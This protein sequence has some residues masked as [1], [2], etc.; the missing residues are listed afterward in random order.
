[1]S[2]I[3]HD[4]DTLPV[5]ALLEAYPFMDSYF[6]SAGLELSP[7]EPLPLKEYLHAL[8]EEIK[9]DKAINVDETVSGARSYMQ[10]MLEFLGLNS[11]TKVESVCILPGSTKSGEPEGFDRLEIRPRRDYLHCGPHRFRKKPA[12]GRHRV[13]GPAGHPHRQAD[14]G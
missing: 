7:K 5:A 12:S 10:Q 9:E 4:I 3:N 6:S 14:P 8:E 11:G 2:K 13:D 1:M